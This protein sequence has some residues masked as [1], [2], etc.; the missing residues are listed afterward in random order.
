M[1]YD[2]LNELVCVI[3]QNQIEEA[4]LKA[5]SLLHIVLNSDLQNEPAYILHGYLMVLSDLIVGARKLIER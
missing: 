4:L 3:N 1:A 2:S 5:E